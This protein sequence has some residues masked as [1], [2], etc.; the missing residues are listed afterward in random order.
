MFRPF[1]F[2]IGLRYTR[3]KRRNHF[4]S[5]I[6]LASMLG[7]ALGVIVLITVLSVMNGFDYEITHR[8]FDMTPQVT[9]TTANNHLENWQNLRKQVESLPDVVGA[10]PYVG[11]QAMLTRTGQVNPVIVNGVIPGEE[12]KV[13]K[14]GL[15]MVEGSF[16]NL[17][18]GKFGIVMGDEL[19]ASLGLLVGDKVTVVIAQQV[20]TP[21]GV[22]PQFKRFTLVGTFHVGGALGFDRGVVYINMQ[23]AQALF[24]LGSAVSGMRLKINDLYAAPKVT[25]ELLPKLPQN[26]LVSNWTQ[27]YGEFFHVIGLEK[28]MMFLILLLIIAVAVFNLVSTL[29]MV[30][31]DKRAEIAI[32]RTLG[33][34]SRTIMATFMVQG[35]II[36]ISGMILGL[37]GGVTLA[38][39]VT[40]I[41][42]WIE[43]LF[44]VHLI[45]S[46][47]YFV[48]YLPSKLQWAD[49]YHICIITVI[50]SLIA[51]LYPAWQAAKTQPAEALRYE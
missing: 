18:P 22:E 51:T 16:S 13:S 4:I 25:N 26:Y 20:V 14:V 45:S 36:G 39:N 41:E 15:K 40:Q 3:A 19:A 42:R 10:A 9:I 23:D 24:R 21:V 17:Q 43:K 48:D 44:N 7:I 49:V 29:V 35:F 31:N 37:I 47:F 33:A 1:P 28:N 34:S 46:S 32:L 8:I 50:M 27:D 30:V 5:F 38:L 12:I 6:S 11:G 2:Y